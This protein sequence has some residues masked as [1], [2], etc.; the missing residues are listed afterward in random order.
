MKIVKKEFVLIVSH[1]YETSNIFTKESKVCGET[2]NFK[3][4]EWR[5]FPFQTKINIILLLYL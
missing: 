5:A 4:A 1:N 3:Y 2:K